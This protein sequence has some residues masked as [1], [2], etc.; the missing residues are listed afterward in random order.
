MKVSTVALKI[1]AHRLWVEQIRRS[2][3][4][5]NGKVINEIRTVVTQNRHFTI[6]ELVDEQG[7]AFEGTE[8]N[9]SGFG[10]AP[11]VSKIRAQYANKLR[12][13]ALQVMLDC[14]NSNSELL[15][16]V[17]TGC[18]RKQKRLEAVPTV[19]VCRFHACLIWKF[20]PETVKRDFWSDR[21]DVGTYRVCL[22]GYIRPAIGKCSLFPL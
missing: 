18:R 8:M 22:C 16:T 1:A 15:N 13:E 17:I 6:Q 4:S 20:C 7:G 5:R 14:S 10:H 12:L 21:Q 2:S 9:P 3:T 11:S 19:I